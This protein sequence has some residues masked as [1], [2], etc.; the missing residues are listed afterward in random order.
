V[1]SADV[2]VA[3]AGPATNDLERATEISKR[4]VRDQPCRLYFKFF[5]PEALS[6]TGS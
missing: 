6:A 5:A 3:A 4:V 1:A 2:R